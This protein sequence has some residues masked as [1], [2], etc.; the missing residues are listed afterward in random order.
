MDIIL[1]Y[2]PVV[3]NV[4]PWILAQVIFSMFWEAFKLSNVG[5]PRGSCPGS[6]NSFHY[7]IWLVGWLLVATVKELEKDQTIIFLQVLQQYAA[8]ILR[9]NEEILASFHL[10]HKSAGYWK[11][12]LIFINANIPKLGRVKVTILLDFLVSYAYF[13]AIGFFAL[14]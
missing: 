13:S 12:I 3:C 10:K 6:G 5:W 11:I 1:C 9:Y 2:F 4:S 14:Q 7:S 8:S